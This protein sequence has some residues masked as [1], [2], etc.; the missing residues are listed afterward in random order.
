MKKLSERIT[1]Y[2]IRN[3][4]VP[5]ESY[6]IYQYGFQAGIEMLSC[7]LVSLGIAVYLHMI[8][9]FFVI[10]G[11]FILLRTYA[12]GV[13]LNSFV[14]CLLCSV[15]VQTLVLVVHDMY[16][17]PISISSIILLINGIAIWS[18]SPVECINR[19]LDVEEKKHCKRVVMRFIF[20]IWLFASV[21]TVVGMEEIVSLMAVTKMTIFVS[22]CIGSIKYRI[23][24]KIK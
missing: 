9:E 8:L 11:I 19:E 23:E 12:G 1:V 10:T 18:M 4:V 6:A 3:G 15:M 21:I 5:E 14:G 17:F 22:Q 20:G 2:V 7:F 24:K 13:H 16:V